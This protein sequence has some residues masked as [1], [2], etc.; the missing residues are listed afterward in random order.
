MKFTLGMLIGIAWL[1]MANVT[2]GKAAAG[3]AEGHPDLFF[4]WGIIT[5]FLTIAA[6][7]ALWGTH[8]HT[9]PSSD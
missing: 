7:G 1:A 3:R 6:V 2:Y 5:A 9:R 4:W 8:L